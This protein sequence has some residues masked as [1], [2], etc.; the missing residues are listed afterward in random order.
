MKQLVWAQK[1]RATISNVGF[2][3]TDV[4]GVVKPKVFCLHFL[5]LA[6]SDAQQGK[7]AFF[8]H[9]PVSEVNLKVV[10]A[11]V[12]SVQSAMWTRRT[13]DRMWAHKPRQV[14]G[15]TVRVPFRAPINWL[16]GRGGFNGVRHLPSQEVPGHE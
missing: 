2:P 16:K 6:P 5:W 9:I 12:G 1:R 15:M 13:H 14:I 3:L 10:I 4:R 8:V 7:P 11:Q